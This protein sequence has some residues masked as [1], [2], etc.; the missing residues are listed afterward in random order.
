MT[1]GVD[2]PWLADPARVV[3]FADTLDIFL[4]LPSSDFAFTVSQVI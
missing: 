3:G 4:C 2:N 1:V